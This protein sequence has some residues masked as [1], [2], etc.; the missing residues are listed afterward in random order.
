MKLISF[1][2]CW[3]SVYFIFF[4]KTESAHCSHFRTIYTDVCKL[5][6]SLTYKHCIFSLRSSNAEAEREE[7]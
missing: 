1:T 3:K 7:G 4:Q 2:K 5:N 6:Y